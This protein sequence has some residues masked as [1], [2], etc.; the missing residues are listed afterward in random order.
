MSENPKQIGKYIVEGIA[1]QGNAGV[2]YAGHDPFVNRKVAIKVCAADDGAADGASRLFRKMFYNEAHTAALLDHPNIL[3]VL[4]AGEEA[5]EPYIIMEFVEGGTTLK[6]YCEDDRLLPLERV[7]EIG[8]K[9]AKALDY[10]HRRGVVHRDIKPSN[11]MLNRNGDVKIC[12]F[13]IAQRSQAEITQ[14]LGIVGSPMYMSPEQAR[15]EQVNKQT[16][17]YSLGVVLFELLTGQL[18]YQATR[19]TELVDNVINAVPP[20]V[21]ELRPE[22]P[23]RLAD[24]LERALAKDLDARM[25]SGLQM[26]ADLARVAGHLDSQVQISEEDK[27]RAVRHLTFFKEFSDSEVWEVIRASRWKLCRQGEEIITEGALEQSF[28]VI[29]EGDVSVK[30]SGTRIS[31]LRAGDCFGEMGYLTKIRRTASI[32]A[33]ADVTV[34][35]INAAMME[36]ASVTCQLRFNKIFLTTLIERLARTSEDLTRERGGN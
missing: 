3:K 19:F 31:T 23:V 6:D 21:T 25:D 32:S 10:A 33:D 2:V 17:L 18:P 26:A 5:G 22:L 15:E 8:F 24:I 16:D 36:R 11:I 29:V 1:G 34:M 27:F 35:E 13:G 20:R 12:D 9:C 4:D 7:M 28:Y 14:V 30:K